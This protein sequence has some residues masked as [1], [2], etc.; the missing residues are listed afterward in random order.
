MKTTHLTI[1]AGISALIMIQSCQ[2]KTSRLDYPQTAKTDS[3]DVYFNTQ[4]ADPYRWL[5]DDNSEETKAWVEAQNEVTNNY[6]AQIPFRDAIKERLAEVWAYTRQS[7]PTQK[8]DYLFYSRH[9]GIS[10]HA[11]VYVKNITDS[12]ERVLI[13]PNLFSEDGTTSLAATS[14]SSDGQHV[15]YAISKGGSDWQEVFIRDV[16][17]GTDLEDHL[18]HIKFSSF[19]W[20]AEGFY[21]GRYEQPAK[22]SELSGSNEYQKLY[23]HKLGTAQ[24]E[25]Q[26]VF[27]DRQNPRHMFSAEVDDEFRYL[28]LY[29]SQSTHGNML[30][31]KDLQKKGDWVL[32]DPDFET[33]TS[34]IGLVDEHIWVLTNYEAPR[35][36][37]MAIDPDNPSIENWKEVLPESSHVLNS[38]TLTNEFAVAN[39]MQD[40]QSQLKVFNKKGEFLY[41]IELPGIASVSD[42]EPVKEKDLI[43]FNYTSYTTPSQ[44]LMYHLGQRLL[45]EEF[46]PVVDFKSEDYESK[47]V[48]VEAQDGAQVPVSIV[49]KKGLELNG[50]HPALLYGYGGF[51]VVY[52]PRFDVRLIPWLENG[53]IYVNAH[54]R[55]GGEY[56]DDW[57]RGGTL[58]NKQ[59]VFDDFILA[60]EY[61]IAQNYTNPEKLAIMGGSNGGLL[62]GAVANQRPDLFKVAL[63]AVGVMDMLR[64]QHFTIGW[65]WAGDYGRSDENE[66]M[67]AYLY[68]YSPLH[69]IPESEIF[70]ATM[71]TTADHDDRVV[72]AH[73]FKYIATLQEKYKG[74][75]P[76]IIRIETKAG[77]G[78]G[79]PLSMQ[80][81]EVADKWAFAWYN[82]GVGY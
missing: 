30:H 69:N 27:E 70:P 51:N 21:Y 63:P 39:Y 17:T 67:F 45:E 14:I 9:D 75:N 31:L 82:M 6:L 79:K 28:M 1:I 25:D 16:A 64:Y 54:I 61:I 24:S 3:V 72:P 59:R 55:G 74:N 44:V 37:V 29:T 23:Y 22:G 80:I 7:A 47:I 68:G 33:E 78:A 4:V 65:A 58:L 8:G 56:G 36:R 77:H 34:F 73:S 13:D 43:Y 62:V 10:N 2:K 57:Y 76:V 50:N 20:D 60:A 11:V 49:H 26:L 41:D 15:A 46:T 81:Q 53:G 52:P 66:E 5:E 35:Y 19:S 18:E 42:L 71:V 48:F 40:V 32:A 12:I 38:I